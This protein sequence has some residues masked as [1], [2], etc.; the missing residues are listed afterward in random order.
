[1]IS[2]SLQ[3]ER[4]FRGGTILTMDDTRPR[5]EALAIG[6]GRILAD[7]DEAAVMATRGDAT[8]I[9][10]LAGHTLMPSFID[11]HG[12]VANAPQIVKWANVSGVPAGPVTCI[13]D[14]L[15]VL[16][17]F[18]RWSSRSPTRASRSSATATATPQST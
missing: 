16:E 12:H 4:I 5:V 17:E 6:S 10:D 11:A 15:R 13:A 3:A 1:M 7:G 18:T 14:I 9:V 8:E 2:E